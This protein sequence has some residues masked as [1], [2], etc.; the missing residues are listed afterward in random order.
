VTVLA[1]G[2]GPLPDEEHQAATTTGTYDIWHWNVAGDTR[3]KASTTD[4]LIETIANSI[5]ANDAH[6]ATINELC[7]NQYD[8]L[9]SALRSGGWPV[10]TANFARFVTTRAA[11][12]G[13]CSDHAYGNALFSKAPLGTSENITL[14]DTNTSSL[15]WACSG[16]VD[17]RVM[18]PT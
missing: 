18:L 8:A 15:E 10:D 7:R 12:T 9:I 5:V 3:H 17:S 4:D 16:Y 2:C 1:S 14:T 6:F 13:A 11:N